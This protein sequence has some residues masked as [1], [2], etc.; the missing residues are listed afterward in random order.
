MYYCLEEVLK[1]NSID[2]C[3]V[4]ANNKVYNVTNFLKLH[5]EHATRIIPKA[6]TDVTKDYNFHSKI[7]LNVWKEY[8]IG[9]IKKTNIC[10]CFG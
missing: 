1:H 9:S 3:W 4:I 6:G 7:Q 2:D 10:S 5:P 8:C